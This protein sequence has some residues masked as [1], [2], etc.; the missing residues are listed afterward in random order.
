MNRFVTQTT[1]LL[2]LA[3]SAS[4]SAADIDWSRVDQA[5]GKKGSGPARRGTQVRRAALGFERNCRRG[6]H[7]TSAG[8]R[9]VARISAGR[10]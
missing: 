3:L 2:A 5:M 10:R 4:A 8:V 6:G 7:Q 1:T 9:F